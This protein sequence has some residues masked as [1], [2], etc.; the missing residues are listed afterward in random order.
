MIVTRTS[1]G[2][3]A[4]HPRAGVAAGFL[5]L[6]R[7]LLLSRAGGERAGYFLKLAQ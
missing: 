2:N 6:R 3:A 7:E 1:V 5:I 4:Y